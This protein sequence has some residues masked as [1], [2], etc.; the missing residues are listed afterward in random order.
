M[1]FDLELLA[2][3][4]PKPIQDVLASFTPGD[5]AEAISLC[6]KEGY[7]AQGI[8]LYER[9][10]FAFS[11]LPGHILQKTNDDYGFCKRRHKEGGAS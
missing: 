6:R 9:G 3:E 10:G 8:L 5:V 11:G 2:Q 1:R 7:Y 4:A